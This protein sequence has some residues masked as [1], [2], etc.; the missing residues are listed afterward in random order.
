MRPSDQNLPAR[1]A[2]LDRPQR[3]GVLPTYWFWNDKERQ[4][5][6]VPLVAL[7][8]LPVSPLLFF[9]TVKLELSILFLLVGSSLYPYWVMGLVERHIRKE[10]RRRRQ[11][12]HASALEPSPPR[13]R[14]RSPLGALAAGCLV[15]SLL[16]AFNVSDAVILIAVVLG[17]AA[18][19][20]AASL[21]RTRAI[22]RQLDAPTP[23]PAPRLPPGPG[24]S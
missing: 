16:A 8:A 4:R 6:V 23:G 11:S 9:L 24:E 10:L 15:L 21:P 1:R 14:G 2:L 3:L 19:M 17:T 5:L 7:V 22:A 20:M 13:P 18:A 12:G